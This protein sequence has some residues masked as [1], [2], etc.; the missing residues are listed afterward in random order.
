VRTNGLIG[1]LEVVKHALKCQRDT[2]CWT[3]VICRDLVYRLG[4][5]SWVVRVGRVMTR[6]LSEIVGTEER[7]QYGVH[8]VCNIPA[9]QSNISGFL[10]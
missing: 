6:Y 8:R 1:G 9:F 5:C 4:H 10:L 7:L 3:V 2:L